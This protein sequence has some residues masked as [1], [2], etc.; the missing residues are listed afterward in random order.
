MKKILLLLVL[1][2]SLT[3]CSRE[4][5]N[6]EFNGTYVEVTPIASRTKI[7]FNSSTNLTII[8]DG[9]STDS[10]NYEIVENFIYIKPQGN[11]Q[12]QKLDFQKVSDNEFKIINLYASIPEN[13][14]TYMTFKK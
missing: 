5:T 6:S 12:T 4:E 7:I 2:F 10:F 13:E 8:K 1:I 3:S 9:N 11:T 14:A